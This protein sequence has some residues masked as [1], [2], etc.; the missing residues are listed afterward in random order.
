MSPIAP[1]ARANLT[2]GTPLAVTQPTTMR[3]RYHCLRL[4][5]LHAIYS[6]LNSLTN[7]ENGLSLSLSL[8]LPACLPACLPATL[9]DVNWFL[10]I[11]KAMRHKLCDRF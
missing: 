7:P 10:Q 2:R 1:I 3:P 8:S 6:Q 11:E 4:Q 5:I 9:I